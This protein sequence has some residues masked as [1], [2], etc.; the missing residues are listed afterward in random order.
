MESKMNTTHAL[1]LLH[2]WM[3]GHD[4]DTAKSAYPYIIH[5]VVLVV[6]LLFVI[7]FV[8]R[9]IRWIL[10]LILHS[11]AII[12]FILLIDY[13]CNNIITSQLTSQLRVQLMHWAENLPWE[14]YYD[15]FDL[16]FNHLG[17]YY[18]DIPHSWKQRMDY[19]SFKKQQNAMVEEKDGYF[20][21]IFIAISAAIGGFVLGNRPN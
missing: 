6:S 16:Y 11:L 18:T 5:I 1:I 7:P 21:R 14:R 20:L 8:F 17:R 2:Q 13:Y 15:L 19:D 3:N 4:N 9:Q 10:G 12:S